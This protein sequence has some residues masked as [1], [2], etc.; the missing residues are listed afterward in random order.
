[1][2]VIPVLRGLRQED[3]PESSLGLHSE[4]EANLHYITCS[5]LKT[6]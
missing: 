2:A 3:C 5:R 1:M 6:D 4:F